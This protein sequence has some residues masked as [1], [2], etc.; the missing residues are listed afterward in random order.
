ME[1]SQHIKNLLLT[2]ERVILGGFGAFDSKHIPAQINKETKTMTPPYKVVVFNPEYTQDEGLLVQ[3]LA[4]KEGISDDSAKEQISEYVKTIKTRLNSGEKVLFP[5]LGELIKTADGKYEFSYISKDNLLVDSFGLPKVSLTEQEISKPDPKKNPRKEPLQ[6]S[7][8]KPATRKE[9]PKPVKKTPIAK[10]QK[11]VK[12]QKEK[13]VKKK[14][15]PVLLIIFGLIGI[16]LV[17]V[18]F[19][20]PDLWKKGYDFSSEKIAYVKENVFGSNDDLEIITPDQENNQTEEIAD[21]NIDTTDQTTNNAVDSSATEEV[22]NEEVQENK[23][24]EVVKDNTQNAEVNATPNS[25]QRGKY[26]IIIS[27]VKS[28]A[29]AKKEQKRYAVKGISTNVLYVPNPDRY[30]ISIGEF[31]SAKAAQKF[32]SDFENQHGKTNAWVWEKR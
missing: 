5:E 14:F 27:S 32:F 4:E 25:A 12:L 16:L 19:F 31:S 24:Q 26:Y 18:Y 21:N 22:S 3:H 11:P 8:V 2:N 9:K 17:A 6:K 20:K 30:R 15:W 29:S 1:I 7:P 13:Q 23:A 10:N 28:E